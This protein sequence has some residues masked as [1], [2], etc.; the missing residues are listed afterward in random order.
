MKEHALSQREAPVLP[1][2]VLTPIAPKIHQEAVVHEV[3]KVT[4]SQQA[5]PVSSREQPKKTE[6]PI[7]AA[8]QD[9]LVLDT[10]G[11]IPKLVLTR[12]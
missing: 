2:E 3:Q 4:H 1:K 5:T 7:Q 10:T 8:T 11:P 6:P 12:K 9:E